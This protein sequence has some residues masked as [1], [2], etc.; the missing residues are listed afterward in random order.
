MLTQRYYT[1]SAKIESLSYLNMRNKANSIEINIKNSQFR[2]AHNTTNLFP[3]L[4]NR[5]KLYT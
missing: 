3:E 4:P 1:C 2:T 5:L